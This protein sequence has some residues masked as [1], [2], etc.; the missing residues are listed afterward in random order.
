MGIQNMHVSCF[1]INFGTP[2]SHNLPSVVQLL[3]M[4]LLPL[5]GLLCDKHMVSHE[6]FQNLR[7]LMRSAA[8]L[9]M[10]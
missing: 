2:F 1:A 4:S 8:R 6:S 3:V 5:R 10:T 9:N 7:G